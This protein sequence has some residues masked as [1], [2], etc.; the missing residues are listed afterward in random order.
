[1]FEE[2][3]VLLVDDDNF[4]LMIMQ[5]MLE[6]TNATI[7]TARNGEEA[8]QQLEA[9]PQLDIM[10]LDLQMP[11][12]D[13]FQVLQLV[14]QN[15]RLHTLP[16]IVVTADQQEVTRVLGMGANDFLPKPFNPDEMR[17]RVKNHVRTKRY[18][19]LIN[20]MN[21]VLEQKVTEKTVALREALA[22]SQEAEYEICLRLGRASEF[23]DMET[24]MHTRRISEMSKELALLA[25][26][27]EGD[28][29][30]LRLA[31]PLHDVGK[32]GIPDRILLK[33][34]KLDDTEMQIMKLHT[35]IGGRILSEGDRFSSLS[36]GQIVALQHHEKWDGSGY[37]HGLKGEEIHIFARI[38]MV[39]DI[40]DALASDRPYKKAFPLD[41]IVGIMEDGRG[42]FFDPRLLQLFFDNLPQF[43]AIRERLKDQQ[44]EP[45]P[46]LELLSIT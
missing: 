36:A 42:Q 45:D 32:I 31:S 30:V 6:E 9:N 13:G 39:A 19:D 38:V 37:P 43:V 8:L 46:L 29:E 14:R 26:L 23:R 28:A 10:L 12:M 15:T 22:L 16:V 25:G 2:F 41:T 7:L 21:A 5:G 34:G 24:G 44:D 1:M 4:N 18:Q 11:V 40:F 27:S 20:N 35:T 33:P 17:M 3:T